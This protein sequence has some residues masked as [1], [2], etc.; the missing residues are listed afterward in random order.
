MSSL[1]KKVATATKVPVKECKL[2]YPASASKPSEMSV[3]KDGSTLG[4]T[5]NFDFD[6]AVGMMDTRPKYMDPV[7]KPVKAAPV[8]VAATNVPPPWERRADWREYTGDNLGYVH[9]FV[10]CYFLRASYS[11]TTF[12]IP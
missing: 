3:M 2:Y 4:D 10:T 6:E 8:A 12:R 5:I 1:R 9:A 11:L 7:P